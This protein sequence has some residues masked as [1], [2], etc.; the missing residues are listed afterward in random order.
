MLLKI[1]HMDISENIK[2]LR[3]SLKMSQTDIANIL[4]TERSNYHRLENRGNKLTLEQIES[5]ANAMNVSLSDLLGLTYNEPE[6]KKIKRHLDYDT[7]N[8]RIRDLEDDKRRLKIE[9]AGYESLIFDNDMEIS[10]NNLAVS[11]FVINQFNNLM[12]LFLKKFT[13]TDKSYSDYTANRINKAFNE[14]MSSDD[15]R[16]FAKLIFS[17]YK[18]LRG[19]ILQENGSVDMALFRK[20]YEELLKN[21][22]DESKT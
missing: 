6:W 9:I 1:I 11:L 16:H 22:K 5:I 12:G 10:T 15:T 21:Y 3:E 14:L 4:G 20:E 2:K 7:F 13:E 17:N 8:D 18:L 19:A